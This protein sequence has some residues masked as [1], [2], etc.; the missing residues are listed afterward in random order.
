MLTISLAK[1]YSLFVKILMRCILSFRNCICTKFVQKLAVRRV[2]CI[3]YL[4]NLSNCIQEIEITQK[5]E[6][7]TQDVAVAQYTKIDYHEQNQLPYL[8][9][10]KELLCFHISQAVSFHGSR[11][12]SDLLVFGLVGL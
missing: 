8:C 5:T 7:N 6:N 4:E 2:G 1:F 10:K 9:C 12:S 11:G 3:T